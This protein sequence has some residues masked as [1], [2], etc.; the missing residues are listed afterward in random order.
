MA[1]EKTILCFGTGQAV[2]SE[3]LDEFAPERG[4]AGTDPLVHATTIT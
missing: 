2:S 3:F 1:S 4:L